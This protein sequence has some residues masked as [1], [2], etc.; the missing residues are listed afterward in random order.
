VDKVT[1]KLSALQLLKMAG[2]SEAKLRAVNLYFMYFAS[3]RLFGIAPLSHLLLILSG[4]LID[5]FRARVN[6]IH[7]FVSDA[8]LR[9]ALLP[10]I[11]FTNESAQRLLNI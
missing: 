9:F 7:I 8:K 11:F 4:Q 3:L 1:H 6:S 5:H 10:T 2:R